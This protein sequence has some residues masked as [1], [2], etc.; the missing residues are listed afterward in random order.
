[1][2]D[3]EQK[4]L[5]LALALVHAQPQYA[6]PRVRLEKKLTDLFRAATAKRGG[7]IT[8]GEG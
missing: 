7:K 5:A 3:T 2:T 8:W 4:A 6:D 1:M